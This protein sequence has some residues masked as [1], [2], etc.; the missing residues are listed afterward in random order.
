LEPERLRARVFRRVVPGLHCFNRRKLQHHQPLTFGFTFD[1]HRIIGGDNDLAAVILD[2]RADA[3]EIGVEDLLVHNSGVHDKVTL[4]GLQSAPFVIAVPGRV[5]GLAQISPGPCRKVQGLVMAQYAAFLRAINVGT[6]N[7]ITMVKLGAMFEAAG[8]S[9]VSSYLQSGNMFF[10]A[11]GEADKIEAGIEAELVANGLK[12]AAVIIRSPQE[13][14]TLIDA[15]PFANY[16]AETHKFS[17]T[18]LKRPPTST[19]LE[20]VTKDGVEVC[21]QD[22]RTLCLAV[23]SDAPLSGGASAV[24]D[25]PWGVTSTT[26]WWNVVQAVVDR[27]TT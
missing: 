13:L 6:A 27:V 8:C 10:D 18:F 2:G 7:R 24:I 21:W 4:H 1:R 14:R 19:P 11:S 23:P 12:N 9:N 3:G 22:E 5:A 25:K 20:R 15:D 17:T 16:R 26:R